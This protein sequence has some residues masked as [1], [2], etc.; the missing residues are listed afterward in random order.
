MREQE[1]VEQLRRAGERVHLHREVWWRERAPFYW[2][3]VLELK[4]VEPGS[5]GPAFWQGVGG[6]A[7]TV[8][9][10]CADRANHQM[11]QMLYEREG[12]ALFS[13]ESISGKKRNQVR[14]GLR[15]C[16]VRRLETIE[17]HFEDLRE[18]NISAR[19]RTGVGRP[20]T[21]YT[22][23]ERE[24]K[25]RMRALFKLE[26][27]SWWGAFVDRHLVGYYY[28]YA[29]EETLIIDTA[30]VH[31]DALPLNATDA[32][33]FTLMEDALNRENCSRIDY[34]GWTPDDSTLTEFK[35]KY[36]FVARRF[37]AYRWFSLPGRAVRGLREWRRRSA[38]AGETRV[39]ASAD[40]ANQTAIGKRETGVRRDGGAADWSAREETKNQ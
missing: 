29:V 28:C 39:D 32:L 13:L 12:E 20:E 10:E 40:P 7:H 9:P 4:P 2:R 24:W 26:G 14:K 23:R 15:C 5:S 31:S 34:G 3:P 38:I 36:G 30:K 17:E 37:P 22:E 35:S 8:P 1:F 25:A 16:E 33:L 27:R 19:R 21:Y 18:I 6:Y 11:V